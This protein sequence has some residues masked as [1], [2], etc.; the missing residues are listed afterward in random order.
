MKDKNARKNENIAVSND[1]PAQYPPKPSAQID[2][3]RLE[4]LVVKLLSVIIDPPNP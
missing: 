1:L 4:N 2:S 3:N